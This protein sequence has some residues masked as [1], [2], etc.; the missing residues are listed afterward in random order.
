M[1]DFWYWPKRSKPTT[2]YLCH[3]LKL[4]TLERVQKAKLKDSEKQTIAVRQ[5]G[6][7]KFEEQPVLVSFLFF[8]TLYVSAC[9]HR[10]S[11]WN[12]ATGMEIKT[13]RKAIFLVRRSVKDA[14]EKQRMWNKILVVLL[15]LFSFL[16]MPEAS[17]RNDVALARM[18]GGGII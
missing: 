12:Y 1:T 5:V 4:K 16:G 2:F 3:G 13:S 18:D 6:N 15:S 8:P 9:I 10:G 14:S 17:P 7:S 11:R